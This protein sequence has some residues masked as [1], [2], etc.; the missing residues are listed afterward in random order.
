MKRKYP[1]QY[2]QLSNFQP[3]TEA[4]DAI[5]TSYK[6]LTDKYLRKI[7]SEMA[8]LNSSGKAKVTLDNFELWVR[9]G[10]S[11]TSIGTSVFSEDREILMP[12]L[13]SDRYREIIRD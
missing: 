4:Y 2:R 9:E 13:E 6:E 12:V 11:D 8:G 7:K 5:R 10:K 3:F 1:A